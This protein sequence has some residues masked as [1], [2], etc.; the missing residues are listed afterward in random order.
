MAVEGARIFN[1]LPVSLKKYCGHAE[2]FKLHLDKFLSIIPDQPNGTSYEIST[3]VDTNCKPCNK[4]R[5]WTKYLK[6]DNWTYESQD[7]D[8]GNLR[9]IEDMELPSSL[10]PSHTSS[11]KQLRM[12]YIDGYVTKN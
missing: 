10:P 1:S 3:A 4:I 6:L 8:N 9:P 7:K 5:T 11:D 12:R 2:R